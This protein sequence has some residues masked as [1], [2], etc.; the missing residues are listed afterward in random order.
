VENFRERGFI[1]GF[2]SLFGIG[3]GG[4]GPHEEH[5]EFGLR[6]AD[7]EGSPR[8]VFGPAQAY[9]DRLPAYHADL[10]VWS[11]VLYLEL[12]R[13]TLIESPVLA[14]AACLNVPALVFEGRRGMFTAPCRLEGSGVSLE[15]IKSAEKART[16]VIRLVETDGR[17][18]ACR[19]IPADPKTVLEETNLVEWTEEERLGLPQNLW[20]CMFAGFC[21]TGLLAVGLRELAA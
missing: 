10:P 17:Q 14:E 5:I 1:D 16:V 9:L 7:L 11:G 2:L 4:G 3:D 13:G 8:V 12:H 20:V 21:Q 19:I 15:V 6:Q 18:S